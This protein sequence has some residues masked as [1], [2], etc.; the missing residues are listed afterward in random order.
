MQEHRSLDPAQVRQLV[1]DDLC[2]PLLVDPARAVRQRHQLVVLREPVLD[3]LAPADERQ[4]AVADQLELS[5]ACEHGGVEG[6]QRKR[7]GLAA[8]KARENR[9]HGQAIDRR[10]SGF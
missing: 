10:G 3:D 8:E 6:D 7:E 2:K 9:R 5:E 1:E 4:P